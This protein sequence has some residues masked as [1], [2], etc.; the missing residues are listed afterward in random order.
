MF[1][2]NLFFYTID[3]S[4]VD[5]TGLRLYLF[6]LQHCAQG[7]HH[8]VLLVMLHQVSERVKLLPPAHVVLQVRL[9]NHKETGQRLK[10]A[11]VLRPYVTHATTV[12]THLLTGN[13]FCK[14]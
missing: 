8:G 2:F 7:L 10:R 3:L 1:L 11:A 4:L 13:I 12:M 5:N 9:T 6:E 14:T